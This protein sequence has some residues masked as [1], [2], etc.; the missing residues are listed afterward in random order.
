[1]RWVCEVCVCEVGV[2]GVRCVCEVG[3][4]GEVVVFVCR[5]RLM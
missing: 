2:W 3:V 1:M 5:A 4:W